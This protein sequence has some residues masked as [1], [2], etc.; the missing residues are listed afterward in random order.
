MLNILLSWVLD[1]WWGEDVARQIAT[2]HV[3]TKPLDESV[4]WSLPESHRVIV[5][6][7]DGY[8]LICGVTLDESIN[9]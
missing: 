8:T 7:E 1:T 6:T 3:T 2:P 5:A 9:Q 4:V